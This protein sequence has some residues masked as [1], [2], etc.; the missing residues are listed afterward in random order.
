MEGY[1]S[2]VIFTLL[3]QAAA[4][5]MMTLALSGRKADRVLGVVAVV[6][7]GI[8][9]LVSLGHL[10]DP[11]ASV[12]TI[13]NAENSWLSREILF[14]GLFGLSLLLWLAVQRHWTCWLSALLGLGLIYVMSRVYTIPTVPFWNSDVSF[15]VFF[16]SGLLLGSLVVLF[17]DSLRTEKPERL[18]AVSL[19][20]VPILVGLAL[21][22]QTAAFAWQIV[23]VT[24]SPDP[25]LA[26]LH[27]GL[28]VLGAGL[29][30]LML[31]RSAL[32]KA[33]EE[34]FCPLWILS[35]VGLLLGWGGAICGRVLFYGGYSWFGM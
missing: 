9:T 33:L 31:L 8:G 29:F 34:D 13:F 21:A 12:Y 27:V 2:L 28:Q 16:F 15:W 23:G 24:P 25:L 20:G 18:H 17:C 1:W 14:V 7:L 19:G 35:G 4:G 6:L 3:G 26:T 10:S 5:V 22:G 30:P 32:R 11:V